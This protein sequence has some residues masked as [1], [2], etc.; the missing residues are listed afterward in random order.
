MKQGKEVVF[1]E[2]PCLGYFLSNLSCFH[3]NLCYEKLC[4]ISIAPT[5]HTSIA[6]VLPEHFVEKSHASLN[7]VHIGLLVKDHWI[8]VAM[9]NAHH[10]FA[11]FVVAHSEEENTMKSRQTQCRRYCLHLSNLWEA[12]QGQ[13]VESDQLKVSIRVGAQQ[14]VLRRTVDGLQNEHGLLEGHTP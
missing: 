13:Q 6:N 12:E 9:N 1:P 10:G 7:H 8:L 5:K 3:S 2:G 4:P 11:R 14:E